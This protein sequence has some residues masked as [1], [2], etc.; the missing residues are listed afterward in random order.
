MKDLEQII[1]KGYSDI[2]LNQI[3]ISESNVRKSKQKVGLEELKAS[4]LQIGLIHPIIIVEN[5]E[6]PGRFKLIV[7]QRRYM[8]FSELGKEKIPALIINSVSSTTEKI[9]SFGENIH[10]KKLPYD[11]T[12][13][14]CEELYDSATGE[15]FGRIEE[16]SKTLGIS[17]STVSKYLSYR[18]VPDEVREL[19]TNGKL[20]AQLAYRITSAFWPNTEKITKIATYMTKMTKSEWE[21]ALDIGKKKPDAPIEEIIEEAK[22]PRIVYQL[23]IPLDFETRDLL[24]KIAEERKID[25]VTLV[26]DLIED[27]LRS[28]PV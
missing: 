7:G 4:I 19:V 16:I 13:R 14:V 15:K 17:I 5:P 3:D 9:A 24:S 20:S 25:T 21:R 6:R 12:I 23:I 1:I 8:A 2:S 27:F 11:D 10:R 22:K 28:E 26:K 18:L